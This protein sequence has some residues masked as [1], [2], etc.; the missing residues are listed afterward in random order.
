M[1]SLAEEIFK[2]KIVN[3]WQM[4]LITTY[5]TVCSPAT[6]AKPSAAREQNFELE[7]GLLSAQYDALLDQRKRLN[8]MLS[9]SEELGQFVIQA[10]DIQKD[11]LNKTILAFT[12]VTIIFLPLSFVT[13][14]LGM[15]TTFSDGTWNQ[16][17][18]LFWKISLPL[19]VALGFLCLLLAFWEKTTTWTSNLWERLP[20]P[21]WGEDSFAVF[22]S[23]D[24]KNETDSEDLT[25]KSDVRRRVAFA[26][27]STSV[28]VDV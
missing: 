22:D 18:G 25:G 7:R 17:Q 4:G 6:Y 28:D 19:T 12:V 21:Q 9:E 13:S 1:R 2:L 5:E 8:E 23:R 16:T 26:G 15:N 10:T 20:L 24:T 14:Y 11:D 3:K 27:N